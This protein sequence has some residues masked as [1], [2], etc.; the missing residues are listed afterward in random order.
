MNISI[1]QYDK[2]IDNKDLTP[3]QK[4]ILKYLPKNKNRFYVPIKSNNQMNTY[5]K[6]A[7]KEEQILRIANIVMLLKKF[8]TYKNA[9]NIVE[10]LKIKQLTDLE[11]IQKISSDK[12][13]SRNPNDLYH[14]C[15][16]WKYI[17]Q[18]LAKKI[19][20]N[21]VNFGFGNDFKFL[22]IGCG[23]GYKTTSFGHYLGIEPKNLYGTDIKNW[24]PY[25]ESKHD[26]HE[27]NFK[28]IKEDE[29]LDFPNNYFNL[30]T[31][32]LTIHHVKNLDKLLLEIKRIL[33]PGGIL[34][35]VEHD[36][37]DDY[38]KIILDL[39]HTLFEYF[40]DNN[41]NVIEKPNFSDYK[42]WAEWDFILSQYKFEYFDSNYIFTT[43]EHNTRFDNIYYAIYKNEK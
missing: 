21:T 2:F 39:L 6:N 27:F 26:S 9:L 36:C 42:N 8:T 24:G 11:V 31:C 35:L 41:K 5:I 33:K 40:N 25:S 18:N 12:K 29:T 1:D 15:S 19:K 23:N 28:Y 3:C 16:S 38:D 22:D 32:F 7:E 43:I 20:D 37:H 10:Q 34:L 13:L 17:L 14:L 30:V 4:K